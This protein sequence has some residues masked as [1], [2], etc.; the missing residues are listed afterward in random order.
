MVEVADFRA[1]TSTQKL[2]LSSRHCLF[3]SSSVW[4]IKMRE[5]AVDVF[6]CTLW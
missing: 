3:R 1:S 5:Y 2:V 6:I 4:A